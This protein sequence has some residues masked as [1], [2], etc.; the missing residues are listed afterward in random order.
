MAAIRGRVVER[1]DGDAG[2]A[3]IDRIARKYLGGPYPLRE[4]RVAFLVAADFATAQAVLMP[5]HAALTS[6]AATSELRALGTA[7]DGDIVLPERGELRGPAGTARAPA[8]G[9]SS[10]GDRPVPHRRRRRT[11]AVGGAPPRGARRAAQRRPLLRRGDPAPRASFS[12]SRRCTQSTSA[13]DVAVVGAGVRLEALYDGLDHQGRTVPAGC[14]ATVGIAGLTLGGGIGVL[15]RRY[16]LTCDRLAAAQ[17]VLA[18]A[19]SSSAT[20]TTIPTCCGRCAAP[21]E[22]SSASSRHCRCAPSQP[23]PARPSSCGGRPPRRPR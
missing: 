12:T 15:G 22:G 19:T 11:R 4:D 18:T 6:R 8:G 10:A 7:I 9:S 20:P 16:G 3:I 2:W 21:A 17:V 1:V 13:D 5:T 14:G 23:R